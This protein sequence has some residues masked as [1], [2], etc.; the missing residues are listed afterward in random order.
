MKATHKLRAL[1]NVGGTIAAAPSIA[2]AA[3]ALGVDRS[4][5]HRWVTAGKVPRPG[6]SRKPA[7]APDP[8]QSSDARVPFEVLIADSLLA[9]TA[10]LTSEQR[11]VWR[12][13][14]RDIAEA[15]QGTDF[16]IRS[17]LMFEL[18]ARTHWK[19]RR[20]EWLRIF[21]AGDASVERPSGDCACLRPQSTSGARSPSP[22]CGTRRSGSRK[23]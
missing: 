14:Q 12:S 16:D 7:T 18:A 6:G 13:I 9:D 8:D 11:T 23:E 4:S 21:L 22:D 19:A 1:G 15:A 10:A 5:V 20:A 3:K 2:E 17:A